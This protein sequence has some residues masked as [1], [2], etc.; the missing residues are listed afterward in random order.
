MGRTV[1]VVCVGDSLTEGGYPN[2]LQE[3]LNSHEPSCQ[4]HVHTCA[5]I[6]SC[7]KD[8]VQSHIAGNALQRIAAGG[9]DVYLV[10]LGTNDAQ[11]GRNFSEQVFH[12]NMTQIA[13]TLMKQGVPVILVTPAPVE[14]GGSFTKFIDVALVNS[15]IPRICPQVAAAVGCSHAD[16]FSALGG[17]APKHEAFIDGVHLSPE[18]NRLVANSVLKRVIGI[19]NV[20]EGGNSPR[21]PSS[22]IE[23]KVTSPIAAKVAVPAVVLRTPAVVPRTR[24]FGLSLS[25][26]PQQP[27]GYHVG[28]AVEVWSKTYDKWFPGVVARAEGTSVLTEFV[29]PDGKEKEKWTP[30]GHKDLR[31][32]CKS[33]VQASPKR[34]VDVVA[35]S[36]TKK[37]TVSPLIAATLSPVNAAVV[38]ATLSPV[39]AAVVKPALIS[40]VSTLKGF[41]G[42]SRHQTVT[43]G[44]ANILPATSINSMAKRTRA[45]SDP[46]GAARGASLLTYRE[47][48]AVEYLAKT[49]HQWHGGV[50]NTIDSSGYMLSLDVGVLKKISMQ[51]APGRLRSTASTKT[52][53]ATFP[54]GVLERGRATYVAF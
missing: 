44:S 16:A 43:I 32:S 34:P 37:T 45:Y 2:V 51:D 24:S 7:T 54:G 27:D 23:N 9:V 50:V 15:A 25:P 52:I 14:P 48:Q 40:A 20:K 19:V 4:W 12:Q 49:D 42:T 31:L 33:S 21:R 30:I 3:L 38:K 1:N 6:G 46:L 5:V 39:N 17:S 26:R 8:W 22:V 13:K 41:G 18:G 47:G 10:M 35:V 36:P 11:R 53:T 28:A 29:A